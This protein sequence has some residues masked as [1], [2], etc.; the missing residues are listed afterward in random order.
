[1]EAK[2][3]IN[4]IILDA[5]GSMESIYDQA[6]SGVNE[7]IKA[8]RIGQKDHPLN[9]TLGCSFSASQ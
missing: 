2:N 1:M 7:T 3:I 9:S 8:I 5:S 4:L 6:L